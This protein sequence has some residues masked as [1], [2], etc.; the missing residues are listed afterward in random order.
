[1]K[2]MK[3][4]TTRQHSAFIFVLQF[5]IYWLFAVSGVSGGAED[6]T[7]PV[8]QHRRARHERGDGGRHQVHVPL[9]HRQ[10]RQGQEGDLGGPLH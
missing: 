1:M 7:G 5:T 10:G 8:R 9:R 4:T 3:S 2:V 6:V